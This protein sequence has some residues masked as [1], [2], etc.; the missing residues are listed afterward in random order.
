MIMVLIITFWRL[1]MKKIRVAALAI[2]LVML[3]LTMAACS[4]LRKSQRKLHRYYHLQ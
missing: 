2:A 1:K 4:R 3:A